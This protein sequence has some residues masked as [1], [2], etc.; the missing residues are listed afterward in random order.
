MLVVQLRAVLPQIL[1]KVKNWYILGDFTVGHIWKLPLEDMQKKD[2]V[3]PVKIGT[4]SI[5]PSTFAITK[6]N[7]VYVADFQ[8][9]SVYQIHDTS[10]Q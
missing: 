6:R 7:Q 1:I 5:L 10:I 2:K 8:T 3:E 4:F 9:G